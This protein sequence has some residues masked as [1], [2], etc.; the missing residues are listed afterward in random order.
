VFDGKAPDGMSSADEAIAAAASTEPQIPETTEAGATMIYTSGTTGKPKGAFRRGAAN[1]AQLG[2]MLAF[3]GYT[4][5]DVY[6]PTGPLYHSG[7][8]GFMGIA[9]ALG[10]TVVLQ[11]K[12]EPVDW[13]RLVETYKVTTTFSA[14]TPIRM[15]CNLPAEV[16][17]KYDVSS[18]KRMIANA[19]PWSYALKEA[20]LALFP[21]ESLWE[22]YG[23]TELGVDTV[24]E[25][26][27]QRR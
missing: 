14:P 21:E 1:P 6:I 4:P 7:P 27:D 11:R 3:I 10:Q 8:G 16:K 20:Y 17:A 13:L 26:K 24:L 2:A 12:F 25:P 23:S 18:M 19:A 5:D 9:Q 15:V 22:V